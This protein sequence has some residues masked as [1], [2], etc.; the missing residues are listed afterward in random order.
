MNCIVNGKSINY[1]VSG[2]GVKNIVLLHGWG[3]SLATFSELSKIISKRYTVIALDLPGFGAS[4]APDS[5][6]SLEGYAVFLVDFLKKIYKTEIYAVVGHSN[7]GAIALKALSMNILSPDRL[8]LLASSG[9]RSGKSVRKKALNLSAKIV[10]I[11]LSVLPKTT[12]QKIK[13][14]A[15]K[16]I[17]SDLL[18][19]E[20]LQETFKLVVGE[21]LSGQISGV[22]AKTLLIYG[23]EDKETPVSY[24]KVFNQALPNSE[25]MIIQ[26]ASHYLHQKYTE[27]VAAKLESF[28]K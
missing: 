16:K 10:K 5:A 15:Y 17:G 6:W 13:K 18:I 23:S 3:D 25:L 14:V 12:K 22:D 9:V 1:T 7:G 11:P 4:D 19:A 20:N 2:E 26:G 24:G 28:L 8:V 21:D 27:K